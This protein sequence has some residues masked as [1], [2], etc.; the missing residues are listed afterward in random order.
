MSEETNDNIPEDR[1][2]E[3]HNYLTRLLALALYFE[4]ADEEIELSAPPFPPQEDGAPPAGVLPGGP[5][6]L[7][8]LRRSG[9]LPEIEEEV[10]DHFDPSLEQRISP[11]R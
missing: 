8:P 5:L 9:H 7:P 2:E 6:S 1:I 10:V 11:R 3:L 4:T